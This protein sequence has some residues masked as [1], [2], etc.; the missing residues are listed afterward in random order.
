MMT[1][2]E[3][4][5][6]KNLLHYIL[7]S[8][9]KHRVIYEVKKT[10][11]I[12]TLIALFIFSIGCKNFPLI[13][14]KRSAKNTSISDRG[15]T[16]P[17]SSSDLSNDD[18]EDANSNSSDDSESTPTSDMTIRPSLKP[19][20]SASELKIGVIVGPG[21][22]RSFLSVGILQEFHKAKVPI[23]AMIG[24]EW[25]SL[26]AALYA[27]NG[28]ANEMEWQMLK[29]NENLI[30]KKS[31]IRDQFESISTPDL[32]EF[33]Q[34]AFNHKSFEQTRIPFECLTFDLKKKQYFWMKKGDIASAMNYCLASPPFSKP[35]LNNIGAI[36]LKLA[37]ESLRK[38]GANYIIFINTFNSINDLSDERFSP[39]AHVLWSLSE[40]QLLKTAHTLDFIVDTSTARFKMIDFEARRDMIRLGQEIGQRA[41]KKLTSK[42]KI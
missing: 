25:G 12:F 38:K 20:P 24:F 5:N 33:L 39:E 17:S 18:Y 8:N 37:S 6:L 41:V 1:L 32:T 42:L 29:L 19:T 21:F 23:H 27:T 34:K 30:I 14:N 2:K 16:N 7:N 40:Y 10:I 4:L 31:L 28:Q 26:P 22:L 15:V 9:P 11:S 13:E 35:Y 3:G 36:D